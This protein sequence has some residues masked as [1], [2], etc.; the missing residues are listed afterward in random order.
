MSLPVEPDYIVV[1]AKIGSTYLLL[2]GIET[3]TVN[4]TVATTD[5]FRRD[6]QAPAAIPTRT[7]R[8]NSTQWDVTG[9]GVINMDFF[10]EYQSLL[11]AHTAFRLLYGRYDAVITNG[12]RTG[13]V[14]GYRDGT[15]VMTAHNENLGDESTAEITIAGEGVLTWTVGAPA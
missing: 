3:A 12:V 1:Q 6:C 8:V 5:R 11:G 13:T 9:S 4:N 7:V 2:C 10:D 15:G 14:Y